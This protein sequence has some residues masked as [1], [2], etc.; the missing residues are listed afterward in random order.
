M[1]ISEQQA[2]EL[3]YYGK[4]NDG[5]VDTDTGTLRLDLAFDLAFEFLAEQTVLDAKSVESIFKER[6][7]AIANLRFQS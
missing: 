6:L 5:Q 7:S 3:L 1:P 4:T 2:V